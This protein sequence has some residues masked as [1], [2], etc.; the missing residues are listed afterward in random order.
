M[1]TTGSTLFC[2][3][4]VVVPNAAA[5]NVLNS[6]NG[7]KTIDHVPPLYVVPGS[8]LRSIPLEEM[9][10]TPN[11]ELVAEFDG[12][13]PKLLSLLN[14]FVLVLITRALCLR[15]NAKLK[16]RNGM[17]WEVVQMQTLTEND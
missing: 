2:F 15:A 3:V 7:G 10:G 12:L 14:L 5:E 4:I 13:R 16:V 1:I 8:S 9:L 17:D 11:P 6:Q